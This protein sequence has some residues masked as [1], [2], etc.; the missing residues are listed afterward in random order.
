MTKK[1]LFALLMAFSASI[2]M[3]CTSAIISGSKTAN[4][5]PILWK[6]RDTGEEDNKVERIAA[7]D[8][9]LA[10]VALFNAS[11]LKC[12]SA[13]M[14]YNSAGFA[15]MN[16]ASYNLKDDDVPDSKM[17]REGYLMAKALKT[18]KTVDDFENLLK[19]Y[20][21]PMG[22]E[23]NFGVIDAQG[24]GAYFETNNHSYLKFNLSD[25]PDGVLIR[26]NYS[27]SGRTDGGKGYIRHDN[28]TQLI[29]PHIAK[30]DFTPEFF[31][32]TVSKTY[33][34][35]LLGIDYTNSGAKWIIDQDFIPR[36][37]STCT[38]AIEGILPGE[39]VSL[40]TMWIGLGFPPCAELRAVW[41]WDGGL[42]Q[43]LRGTLP[44]GH[45]PL[46]DT[47]VKRKHEAFC[48]TRGSGSHYIN[49][50]VLYNKQGTGYC[51]T[52]AKVNKEA[53]AN[54]YKTLEQRRQQ[55]AQKKSK[56]KK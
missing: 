29:A 2:A 38:C 12:E 50:E 23:A 14:G 26:T 46:C 52:L 41:L 39:D 25:A 42:P 24:N 37:T 19:T 22:V 33:L 36:Y 6:H 18:C 45:S 49:F 47:V 34:H 16:T 43:E 4:G 31:T 27:Y 15:V 7:T 56:R 48:I 54:G 10:Y 32:E 21:R 17:D 51:Q 28:L 20:P 55:L 30:G 53:Y 11:D 5:R 3:A 13:W 1:I 44:N 9:T 35:T 8:S 40:T